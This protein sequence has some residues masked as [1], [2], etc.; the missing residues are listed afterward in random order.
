MCWYLYIYIY[1][2]SFILYHSVYI[3]SVYCISFCAYCVSLWS[4]W[5]HDIPFQ[6]PWSGGGGIKKLSEIWI[7]NRIH[8]K[9]VHSKLPSTNCLPFCLSQYM[10]FL[11]FSVYLLKHQ[12][13]I[14]I[15]LHEF[16]Y[17]WWQHDMNK[18][19]TLLV[20]CAGN[21]PVARGFPAERASSV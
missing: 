10:I 3:T 11:Y 15:F 2:H 20:L 6:L 14:Y 1:I 7:K 9:K 4:K 8:M 12:Q 19:S 17:S 16:P 21:P 5:N 18:L 13:K